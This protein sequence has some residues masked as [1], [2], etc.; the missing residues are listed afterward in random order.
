MCCYTWA[1]YSFCSFS[2]VHLLVVVPVHCCLNIALICLGIWSVNP[3]HLF[4][5]LRLVLAILGDVLFV[6]RNICYLCFLS[7]FPLSVLVQAFSTFISLSKT[8]HWLNSFYLKFV[9]HF[10]NFCFCLYYF[11]SPFGGFN[12]LFFSNF[13]RQNLGLLIFSSFL[14]HAF[15]SVNFSLSTPLQ[16]LICNIIVTQFKIHSNF[17]CGLFFWHMIYLEKDSLISKLIGFF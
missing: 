13:L 3:P 8:Q 9:F 2:L 7:F 1:F 4:Y 16:V 14:L 5:F 11:S 6:I 10:S 12:L 15:K 17:Q